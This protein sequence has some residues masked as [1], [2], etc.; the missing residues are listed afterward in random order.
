V[1]SPNANMHFETGSFLEDTQK[2]S[3]FYE[4][5]KMTPW[6][7]NRVQRHWEFHK[8]YPGSGKISLK[9]RI[10]FFSLNKRLIKFHNILT[11]TSTKTDGGN[12]F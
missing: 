5:Q 9:I 6:E 2:I 7:V 8:N 12:K 1:S 11:P 10:A 3:W 4:L